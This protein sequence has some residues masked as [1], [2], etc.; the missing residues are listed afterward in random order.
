MTDKNVFL[1]CFFS[2]LKPEVW[3]FQWKLFCGMS[4]LNNWKNILQD[5]DNIIF[6]GDCSSCYIN[7]VV[8]VTKALESWILL[9]QSA[10]IFLSYPRPSPSAP[11]C[12]WW[13][14]WR[15]RS[16]SPAR[17]SAPSCR[18][19]THTQRETCL[20]KLG[21]V[22]SLPSPF[23]LW[24]DIAG[25]P[26]LRPPWKQKQTRGLRN[27]L[28]SDRWAGIRS[29]FIWENIGQ[30]ILVNFAA[31]AT[32]EQGT[33]LIKTERKTADFIPSQTMTPS[34]SQ[35]LSDVTDRGKINFTCQ[36]Q[37]SKL[38]RKRDLHCVESGSET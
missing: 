20:P 38:D 4:E 16:S 21:M 8:Q 19:K 32:K 36:S 28:G 26:S 2:F 17:C 30:W 13:S 12:G 34:P 1:S 29:C 35:I 7:V 15:S 6:T 23:C 3:H 10:N 18:K 33:E 14:S 25:I 22:R 24:C 11:R 9:L 27:R 37:E 5:G 31:F